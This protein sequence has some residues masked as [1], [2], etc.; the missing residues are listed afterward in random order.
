MPNQVTISASVMQNL[1]LL[2]KTSGSFD[3]VSSHVN[4]RQKVMNPIDDPVAYYA[5]TGYNHVAGDF[6]VIKDGIEKTL[7]VIK[8]SVNTID[9]AIE[10]VNQMK[11]LA[12]SAKASAD[13]TE[14]KSLSDSYKELRTQLTNLVGDA[15]FGGINLVKA[16][17]DSMTVKLNAAGSNTYTVAG[18]GLDSTTAGITDTSTNDWKLAN[19]ADVDTALTNVKTALGKLRSASRTLG[20]HSKFL[21][22]RVDF[23]SNKIANHK[24]AATALTALNQAELAGELAKQ[25]SLMIG[26]QAGVSVL[27]KIAENEKV[28]FAML[29][30]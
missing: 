7:N 6:G 27:S 24:G 20:D 11:A 9:S 18:I 23:T 26:Q 1:M 10:I 2:D 8:E 12:D 16:S 30:R 5:A 15:T 28:L 22:T 25:N 21:T 19:D 3:L 17:P 14:R 29:G 4:S 13:D